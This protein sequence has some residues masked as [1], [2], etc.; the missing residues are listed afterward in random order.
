M[1]KLLTLFIIPRDDRNGASANEN[2][3]GI[4]GK[5]IAQSKVTRK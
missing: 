4:I 1:K 2:P 3:S 5:I